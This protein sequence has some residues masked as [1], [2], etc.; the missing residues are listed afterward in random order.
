MITLTK[1]E[2]FRT[3]DSNV[4]LEVSRAT[5][6]TKLP[7]QLQAGVTEEELVEAAKG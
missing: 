1:P 5:V 4:T 7:R 2:M 6:K 3:V